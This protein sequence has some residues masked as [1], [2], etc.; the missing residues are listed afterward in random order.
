ML[1]SAP[2]GASGSHIFYDA[3][4][5]TVRPS[6][7]ARMR[8]PS[9]RPAEIKFF[10]GLLEHALGDLNAY[11]REQR[12]RETQGGIYAAA[13]W[14]LVGD[15]SR[16]RA[17]ISCAEVCTP[18]GIDADRVA[19][20]IRAEYPAPEFPPV[21]PTVASMKSGGANGEDRAARWKAIRHVL[22]SAGRPMTAAEVAFEVDASV[23]FVQAQLRRHALRNCCMRR[24]FTR[25]PKPVARYYYREG[26]RCHSKNP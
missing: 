18:L 4:P 6:Q 1:T 16:G 5:E 2:D 14:W 19:A 13:Y 7:W 10:V 26:I 12:V 20:H 15:T 3:H 8:A 17:P 25:G 11:V 9:D 21:D 22:Q 24:R 23:G